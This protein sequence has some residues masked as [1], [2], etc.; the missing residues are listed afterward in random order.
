MNLLMLHL[1]MYQLLIYRVDFTSCRSSQK[2]VR[3]KNWNFSELLFP[4]KGKLFAEKYP[5]HIHHPF[6]SIIQIHKCFSH[7]YLGKVQT[8]STQKR[9]LAKKHFWHI[10]LHGKSNATFLLAL[11]VT[12][13]EWSSYVSKKCLKRHFGLLLT[14]WL[15]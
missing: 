7:R 15:T 1:H 9:K 10:W 13:V 4:S 3:I 2:R 6:V 12:G 8:E 14:P 11:V 5:H